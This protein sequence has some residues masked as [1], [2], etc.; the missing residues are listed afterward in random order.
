MGGPGGEMQGDP[1]GNASQANLQ[2][3]GNMPGNGSRPGRG[4]NDKTGND[5]TVYNEEKNAF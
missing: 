1:N 2:E 4:S 5:E 3:P